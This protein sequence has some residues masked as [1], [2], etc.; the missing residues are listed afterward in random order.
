MSFPAHCLVLPS[1]RVLKYGSASPS[2]GNAAYIATT[3][4]VSGDVS[5]GCNSSLG[6]GSTLRGMSRCSLDL[7][8]ADL[9]GIKIGDNSHLKDNVVV[10]VDYE[11]PTVIGEN[12]IIGRCAGTLL[13]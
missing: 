9:A 13:S 8:L 11:L 6:Y 12:V 5:M 10:H 7:S 3:A 1:C 2:V 4:T